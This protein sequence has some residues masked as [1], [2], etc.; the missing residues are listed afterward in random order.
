MFFIICP[1]DLEVIKKASYNLFIA[2]IGTYYVLTLLFNCVLGSNSK[3]PEEK[4]SIFQRRH[5][6]SKRSD[7]FSPENE[8]SVYAFQSEPEDVPS[9]IPFRR[10]TKDEVSS[11]PPVMHSVACSTDSPPTKKIQPSS[12]SVKTSSTPSSN[13]FVSR[14]VSSNSIAVQVNFDEVASTSSESPTEAP[15]SPT[16]FSN[17]V[18]RNSF[19][20]S[21]QTEEETEDDHLFYIPLQRETEQLIQ[22]VEV[23]LGTEGPTGPNQR[24]IMRAKLVTK[25]PERFSPALNKTGMVR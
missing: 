15:I 25:P 17:T 6:K 4:K 7:A 2:N 9:G 16:V 19:E 18:Q 11:T 21:T 1:N 10:K 24:V 8:S 13:T 22:G 5:D 12:V 23:K 20:C 3:S 14:N